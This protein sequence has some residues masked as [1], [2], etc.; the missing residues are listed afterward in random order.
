M[1]IAPNFLR[2]KT[3]SDVEV[4]LMMNKGDGKKVTCGI[5]ISRPSQWLLDKQLGRNP[6]KL[7][8]WGVILESRRLESAKETKKD[9]RKKFD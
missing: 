6:V 8:G 2:S 3:E 5:L 1:L 9:A 4:K 7:D